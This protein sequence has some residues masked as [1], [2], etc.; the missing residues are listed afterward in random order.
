[1]KSIILAAAI[2]IAATASV[3][4]STVEL[5]FGW[6][7]GTPWQNGMGWK[8]GTRWQNGSNRAIP[9]K[10]RIVRLCRIGTTTVI[11]KGKPVKKSVYGPCR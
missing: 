4:A 3:A 11:I 1:M 9:P 7:N 5:G 10:R 2:S 8:N 6:S